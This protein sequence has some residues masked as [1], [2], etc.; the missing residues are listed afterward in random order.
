MRFLS[1]LVVVAAAASGQ[2]AGEIVKKSA[3]TYQ[4]L[5]SYRFEAQ[6]VEENVRGDSQ[7]RNLT[8]RIAVAGPLTLRRIELKGGRAAALRVYDGQT[9]WD[10][11]PA[12]NQFARS[13]QATYEPPY[14]TLNLIGDPVDTY[15]T[16]D[17]SAVDARLLR[18]ETIEAAGGQRSC[19]V[20]GIPLQRP[21]GGP[22]LER[23][24]TYWID[25]SSYLVLKESQYTKMKPPASD[26]PQSHM[27]A[28][29]YTVA[30]VNEPELEDLFHF[31]PPQGASE[32]AEFAGPVGPGQPLPNTPSPDFVLR[33]LEGK[34]ASWSSFKGKPVLVNF[35]AT[36][37]EPCR[38]E[39]PK[40]QEVQRLFGEKGLI[41]LAI[42]AGETPEVARKYIEEHG[43]T[44]RVLLDHDETVY[45]KFK[46][47]GLPALFLIGRDG[48]MSVQFRGYRSGLDFRE[49]LKKIGVQ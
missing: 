43:Y 7:S 31:Q 30:R 21:A 15:K 2:T 12:P 11:R 1:L 23:S 40:I 32:V 47:F 10:F 42:D 14:E 9:V 22:I 25:K 36:W 19:W 45:G 3:A 39:M 17:E 44:F 27:I 13:D 5:K 46:V 28:A 16:A 8:T 6:V 41:V 35:W 29:T 37:C 48:N 34:E 20:V 33:D 49:E 26:V 38:E 4:S 18:E 24:T